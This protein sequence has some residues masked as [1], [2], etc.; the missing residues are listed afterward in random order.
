MN[1][2]LKHNGDNFDLNSEDGVFA[3]ENGVISSILISLF[4][5]ARVSGDRGFWASSFEGI[6]FGSKLW[7]LMRETQ[8]SESLELARRWTEQALNWIVDDGLVQD[9]SVNVS[10]PKRGVISIVIT[11]KNLEGIQEV[12]EVEN[13]LQ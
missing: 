11:F 9:L 8:S 1:L 7:S 6:D 10:Y 12:F 13:D 2:G 5:D 4:T 3:I